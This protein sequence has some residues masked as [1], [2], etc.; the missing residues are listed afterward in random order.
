MVIENLLN[1]GVCKNMANNLLKYL[2]ATTLTAGLLLSNG[3]AKTQNRRNAFSLGTRFEQASG[4]LAVL[5]IGGQPMGSTL[6]VPARENAGIDF[7]IENKNPE[8]RDFV[9][10]SYARDGSGNILGLPFARSGYYGGGVAYDASFRPDIYVTSTFDFSNSAG[11]EVMVNY[12]L[13]DRLTY[14]Q[15]SGGEIVNRESEGII[16]NLFWPLFEEGKKQELVELINGLRTSVDYSDNI[17]Q[18]GSVRVRV[19]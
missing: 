15:T 2:A 7:I 17:S 12:T 6:N 16:H 8:N 1:A 4:D 11:Q 18:R 13:I 19:L 5:S 14:E 10:F 9:F 3:A